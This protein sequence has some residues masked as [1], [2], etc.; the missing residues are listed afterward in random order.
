[1]KPFKFL[2]E[3][4]QLRMAMLHEIPLD[5]AVGDDLLFFGLNLDLVTLLESSL[6]EDKLDMEA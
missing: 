3:A 6:E 4:F 5:K 1:M 2:P